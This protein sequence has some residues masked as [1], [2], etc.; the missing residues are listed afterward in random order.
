MDQHQIN[1]IIDCS[2]EAWRL[3][4]KTGLESPFYEEA[5][6]HIDAADA[7][8]I[9]LFNT[10]LETFPESCRGK[11]LEDVD[12]FMFYAVGFIQELSP[13][14]MAGQA[15]PPLMRRIS[16]ATMRRLIA[17]LKGDLETR[18]HY[19]FL[20]AA[21]YLSSSVDNITRIWDVYK[22]YKF[23]IYPQMHVSVA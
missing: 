9:A 23:R 7:A 3:F 2:V 12:Y 21:V 8:R 16:L 1:E 5:R 11:L 20:R 17:E 14:A 4:I 19:D 22:E 18:E 15:D 6:Q 10:Y 13:F